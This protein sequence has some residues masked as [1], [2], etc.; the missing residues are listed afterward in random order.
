VIASCVSESAILIVGFRSSPDIRSCLVALSNISTDTPFDVFICENGGAAAYHG[1]IRELTGANGPCES[2]GDN[3]Q[4]E[5]R[6][7][8]TELERLRLRG[9]SAN[10][11]VGCAPENL[12]YAGGINAWLRPL[13]QTAGWKGVW[14]LNPDTEPYP[15]ALKELVGCA[16]AGDKAMVGST[17]LE[18]GKTDVVRFRGGL[19]W[20]KFAA[21]SVAIGLG[22][23]LRASHDIS[24]IEASMDSPSGASMYVTR[25]CIER[26]GLPD[27]TY[28]LFFED[29]DWGV[30]AKPLG[31]GYASASIVAHKQGTT[32]GS[33]ARL[34]SISRL[35]VYLEHRNAIHFVRKY[36]PW[37]LPLRICVSFLYALRFLL[38]RAPQSSLATVEGILAGLK[39]ETGRPAWYQDQSSI[40]ALLGKPMAEDQ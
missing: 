38:R 5:D 28:F 24:A 4:G 14:I 29:L 35:S 12:G 17:I 7:G 1:L 26:I 11:W 23:P 36:F 16:V 6:S 3:N 9:K 20:E 31:L 27:E 30:K 15:D 21:R 2:C 19:R 8:F 32:T 18:A 33:T 37:T 40:A 22:D 10:V 13:L 25:A 39:G 34:G